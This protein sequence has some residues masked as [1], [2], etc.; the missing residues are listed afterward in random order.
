MGLVAIG[1]IHG[2]R[3]SLKA[4]LKKLDP[5]AKDHLVFIGDYVDRG[6]DSRGVIEDLIELSKDVEC[7]FLRGNH[8]ALLLGYVD[9]GDFETFLHNGG[10]QTLSSYG[11]D[12]GNLFF[13]DTHMQFIRETK[14]YLETEDAVF[15]HAGLRPGITVAENL[16]RGDEMIYLWERSHIR[17][18]NEELAWEK[19]VVCGHTP[20]VRPINLPK[21]I[22]IDTGCVFGPRRPEFGRLTAVRFPERHFV[23][24]DYSE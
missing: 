12:V 5:K 2:C 4:L 21:L 19:T 6:P 14:L 15:V 22:N 24:V 7:T 9:R 11:M 8:E 18:S 1:D 16:A 10:H 17:C 3:R 23:S 20:V 13:P